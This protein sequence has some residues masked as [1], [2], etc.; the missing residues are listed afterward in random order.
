MVCVG[1]HLKH[2]GEKRQKKK[3]KTMNGCSKGHYIFTEWEGKFT[4]IRFADITISPFS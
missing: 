1:N 2:E 4:D 3:K